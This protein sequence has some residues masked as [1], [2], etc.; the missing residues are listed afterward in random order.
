MPFFFKESI[1]NFSSNIHTCVSFHFTKYIMLQFLYSLSVFLK[2]HLQLKFY[3]SWEIDQII[4]QNVL[5][6]IHIYMYIYTHT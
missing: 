6:N 1:Q 5:P 2:K 3:L 4:I